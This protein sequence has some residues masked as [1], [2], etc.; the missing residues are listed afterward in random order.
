[1]VL[2]TGA[3]GLLGI[4]IIKELTRRKTPCIGVDIE[5]FDFTDEDATKKYITKLNPKI[6]IH[7][8]AY[9]KVDYAQEEV[10]LCVNIN[11]NGTKNIAQ[12]CKLI[13]AVMMYISTDYVFNGESN[14]PYETWDKPSPVNIYG[15]TKLAG[16]QHIKEI[17]EEYFIV[18]TSSLFSVN[19]HSFAK[20]MLDLGKCNNSLEVV[21]DQFFSPTYAPDLAITLC[22]MVATNK[23]GTYHIASEN[24][25]SRAEFARAIMKLAN[26]NCTINDIN[27]AQYD[28]NITRPLNCRLSKMSLDIANFNRLPT[29]QNALE[30]YINEVRNEIS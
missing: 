9:T 8:G 6:V 29:W 28:S 27:L 11:S 1:M 16:E 17:M 7:C 20:T 24:F 19:G 4:E 10:E 5:N 3:K 18:R 30:R 21:C 25:C 22:D 23:F 2:V 15:A 26:I 14:A 12:A 13:N